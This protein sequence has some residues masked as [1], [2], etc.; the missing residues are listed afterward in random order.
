[1]KKILVAFMLL[2]SV[3]YATAQDSLTKEY[4]EVIVEF[5]N[6]FKKNDRQKLATLVAY[7]LER[8]YPIPSIKNKEEFLKRFDEVFDSK[9]ITMIVNSNTSKDWS[10]VGWRGVMFQLGDIWLDEDGNC[11]SVN[12]Q[13][14]AEVKIKTELIAKDKQNLHNSL[15]DFRRP[16]CVLETKKYR[17]RIDE[18]SQGKYRYASWKINARIS[19]K[20]DMIVQNG[21]YVPE[22]SGGNHH[23]TFK[24]GKYTYECGVVI[25][26]ED[27]SAPAYLTI[28]KD[29]K[30]ILNTPADLVTP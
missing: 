28:Y 26:G 11:I 27:D 25:I 4:R 22:G 2:I 30:E 12:Y 6:Y 5:I 9:L 3:T 23:Y 20:P 21:E 16:V 18:L 8:E 1:M 19:E 7:P 15:S 24:N 17:I 29:G 10:V 13:S 14:D